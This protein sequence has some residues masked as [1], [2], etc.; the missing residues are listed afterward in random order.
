MDGWLSRFLKRKET[1]APELPE[2]NTWL[3]LPLGNPGEEYAHTRHN[4]GRLMVQRWMERKGITPRTLHEFRTGTL[5]S[6][7][8]PL[9]ALVP[10]TYMN[11]SGQVCKEAVKAGFD[12]TRIILVYDDKDLPLGL[13]RFRMNGSHGGHNGLKSVFEHLGTQ[14][15][16]RLRLGI[17]P[18][19][20]PLHEFVLGEWSE[21]EGALFGPLD[22]GFD[23]F[24]NALSETEDLSQLASKVNAE[25]FWKA[26]PAT[27]TY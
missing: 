10:A 24:L 25:A 19:Q 5:Y 14:D 6:L 27:E 2:K 23:R 15:V 26:S 21:A 16:A 8:D 4:M 20:R 12:P 3:L 18:F 17:G 9:M 1:P 11:L 22:Q 7:R 13:G